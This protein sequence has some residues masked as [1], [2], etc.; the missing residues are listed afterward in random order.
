MKSTER[1]LWKKALLLPLLRTDVVN[2]NSQ[3]GILQQALAHQVTEK[4]VVI[5]VIG[6]AVR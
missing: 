5:N 3:S 4:K 6:E 1:N 2:S